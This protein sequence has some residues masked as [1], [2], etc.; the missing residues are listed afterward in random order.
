MQNTNLSGSLTSIRWFYPK[1]ALF[2]LCPI[3]FG[4][5]VG[6]G[7]DK[8]R[9][10]QQNSET[11]QLGEKIDTSI[12]PRL[13]RSVR[14]QLEKALNPDNLG[15]RA[16][17]NPFIDRANLSNQ[18]ITVVPITPGAMPMPMP[19]P[20]SANPTGAIVQPNQLPPPVAN[21]QASTAN[22]A[23]E[24]NRRLRDRE[25]SARGG[26]SLPP[27]STVFDVDDVEPIG[28]IGKQNAREVLFRSKSTKKV[29]SAPLGARFNNGT[30]RDAESSGV[31]I[32]RDGNKSPEKKIWAKSK[33]LNSTEPE[34]VLPVKNN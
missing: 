14:A 22:A 1:L 29:F 24:M 20:P 16:A 2:F 25:R 7:M 9:W 21:S 3:L 12:Y 8:I 5:V 34:P 4:W 10:S 33:P 30:L 32:E 26:N 27:I 17:Q 15:L 11:E 13:D 23:D 18:K 6:L 19:M 31:Q 28:V